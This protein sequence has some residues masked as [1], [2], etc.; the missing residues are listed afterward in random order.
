[1]TLSHTF[2]PNDWTSTQGYFWGLD[3]TTMYRVQLPSG[4][5]HTFSVPE[6]S[7]GT[8]GAA[9]FGNGDLGFSNNQTGTVY[10]ISLSGASSSSPSATVG[11]HVPRSG[12]RP[13][14]RR[15]VVHRQAHRLEHREDRSGD[16]RGRELHHLDAHGHRQRP[17]NSS[18]YVVDDN[19]PPGVTNVAT[20]TP[21]CTV[22]GNDVQSVEGLL[23]TGNTFSVTLTGTAPTSVGTCFVNSASVTANESDANPDNNTSSVQ[24]CTQPAISIVK[25]AS[26]PTYTS[27]AER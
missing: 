10:E 13:H 9:T 4:T 24:T 25:S 15:V 14:Q 12:R 19:V 7:N 18:G 2:K 26:V 11:G 17:G 22:S 3:G 5:V 21:G 1:M 27:A 6:A 8:Y 20:S 23:A 16:R